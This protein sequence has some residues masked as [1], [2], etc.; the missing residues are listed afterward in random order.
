MGEST[1]LDLVS[2]YQKVAF[3]MRADVI[4]PL[5]SVTANKMWKD[6]TVKGNYQRN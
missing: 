5:E 6:A 3:T 1:D 2:A 4:P